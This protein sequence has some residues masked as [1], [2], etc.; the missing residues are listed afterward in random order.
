MSQTLFVT[1][2]DTDAGK[3][4]VS[5]ALLRGLSA[6]RIAACGFKP[7]ASGAEPSAQGL[8]NADALALRAASAPGASLAEI[9][10]VLFAPAIAPHLA[11]QAAGQPIDPALL[12]RAHAEL[13]GRYRVI[14]VEGAGGWLTPLGPRLLLGD[15]VAQQGWPVL[16]VVRI[17]L[18]CLNHA[19][20]T[21]EAIAARG[22][23][24]AGWVANLAP[25]SSAQAEGMIETLVAHLG[26][27]L[28]RQQA[29]EAVP[30]A[31]ISQLFGA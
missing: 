22:V 26:P 1:G 11:A 5:C 2:T 19:L 13:A 14:V 28:W 16:L 4:V 20:L 6:A 18:G 17:R 7:V 8:A 27:P 29:Q 21:A 9:N 31:V 12:T 23:R 30:K 10:P 24:L 15:W 25:P 3:T